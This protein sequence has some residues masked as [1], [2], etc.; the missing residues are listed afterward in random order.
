MPDLRA[1]YEKEYLNPSCIDCE[2]RK[3][4]DQAVDFRAKEAAADWDP[5]MGLVLAVSRGAVE[6]AYKA[7]QHCVPGTS[8]GCILLRK[9]AE[10]L[11]VKNR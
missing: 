4:Y 1:Q 3:A 2:G 9:V 11:A 8:A 5:S 6:K 7:T 10:V